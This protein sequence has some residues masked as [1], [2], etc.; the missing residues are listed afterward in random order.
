MNQSIILFNELNDYISRTRSE[1]DLKQ[2]GG[3]Y[4]SIANT[5]QRGGG[6]KW[7]NIGL[8]E[9]LHT[10]EDIKHNLAHFLSSNRYVEK[11]WRDLGGEYF[12]NEISRSLIT[13]QTK[14]FFTM[15]AKIFHWASEQP[16]STY[17][18]NVLKL[19]AETL[20]DTIEKLK[21][22]SAGLTPDSI[23]GSL[24]PPNPVLDGNQNLSNPII[25]MLDE[26]FEIA[27][28]RTGFTVGSSR[29]L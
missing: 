2:T 20:E 7:F 28:T 16:P 1:F 27:V 12:T 25:K 19:T 18:D 11:E 15:L 24:I 23:A 5:G 26:A 22:M 9:I 14:P 6:K 21:R 29:H 8:T 10:L 13:V 17:N 4:F 3:V